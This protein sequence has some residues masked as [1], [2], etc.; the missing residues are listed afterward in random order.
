MHINTNSSEYLAKGLNCQPTV[1]ALSFQEKRA[2][3][4]RSIDRTTTTLSHILLNC[5]LIHQKLGFREKY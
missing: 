3:F 5:V 2:R 1:E 4:G